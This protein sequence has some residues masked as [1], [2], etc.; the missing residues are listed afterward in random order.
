MGRACGSRGDREVDHRPGFRPSCPAKRPVRDIDLLI[1]QR[2][3]LAGLTPGSPYSHVPH[4]PA[5]LSTVAVAVNRHEDAQE[6][7]STNL[8]PPGVSHKRIAPQGSS[9][10]CRQSLHCRS[11]TL[12]GI[13]PTAP[14]M[15][16]HADDRAASRAVGGGAMG[17]FATSLE[18][19]H[20]H[21]AAGEVVVA[22][23]V[24]G[25]V[26]ADQVSH[27]GQ[28]VHDV[29]PTYTRPGG[30]RRSWTPWRRKPLA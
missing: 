22:L 13:D 24:L 1:P 5:S 15:S 18:V 4:R 19:A 30:W 25:S 6:N 8:D 7:R 17:Y 21:S 10:A 16:G 11:T 23:H 20:R 28:Y 12:L 26:K 27:P 14:A 2:C 9:R 29:R 3:R